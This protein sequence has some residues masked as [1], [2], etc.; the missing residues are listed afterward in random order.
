[1]FEPKNNVNTKSGITTQIINCPIREKKDNGKR[2]VIYMKAIP[3]PSIEICF[4]NTPALLPP[5]AFH[6]KE[7]TALYTANTERVHKNSAT[8]QITRSPFRYERN[9]CMIY[10]PFTAT[11]N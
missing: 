2:W 11:L 3:R 1:M 5:S 6:T 4:I 10:N 8:I 7:D 9:F